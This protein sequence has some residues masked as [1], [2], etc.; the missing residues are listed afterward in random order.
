MAS[1]LLFDVGEVMMEPVWVLI[2]RLERITGIHIPGRGPSDPAGDPDWLRYLAG[3]LSIDGYW[4]AK[5]H[6]GGYRTRVDMFRATSNQLGSDAFATDVLDLITEAR[7]A[8]I[9]V[10]VL[11][12]DLVGFSGREWVDATP[13]LAGFD[14]FVDSTDVGARKPA[15]APYLKAIADFGLPAEDIV[16]LDDT[17]ACVEGAR[18]VGMVAVHVDP[19][20]RTPALQRARTLVG[21]VEPTAA[22]QLVRAAEA[23]YGACDLAAVQPLFHPDVVIYWNGLR[24]A[25]GWD[26]A[27]QFHLDHLGFSSPPRPE[28]RL[29][30]TLRAAEGDTVCVE[31]EASYRHRRGH[32]AGTRG[33]EFWTL[34]YGRVIEWRAYAQPWEEPT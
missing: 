3:D 23:A 19:T 14:V 20:N 18:A 12:N 5:A 16:F 6:A 33:G 22:E 7:A 27:R 10:G 24:V 11:S 29:R 26:E 1:A 25:A 21:L 9:P 34:R 8:G 32:L 28:Y 31:W 30:K 2:E 13:E 15:A 4:D 17:P